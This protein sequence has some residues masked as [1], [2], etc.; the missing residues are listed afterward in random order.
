M[1]QGVP[2]LSEHIPD[3]GTPLLNTDTQA[4]PSEHEASQLGTLAVL[5]KGSRQQETAFA[6]PLQAGPIARDPSYETQN[7]LER[8]C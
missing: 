6:H 3:A 1:W 4:G 5:A 2:T 8:G 7:F